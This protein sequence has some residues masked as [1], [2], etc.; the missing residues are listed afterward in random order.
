MTQPEPDG[1]LIGARQRLQNAIAALID[2]RRHTLSTGKNTWLDSVYQQ[3]AEAVYEKHALGGGRATPASPLWIAASDCLYGIDH[4]AKVEHPEK[5]EPTRQRTAQPRLTHATVWRLQQIDDRTW[6]PQDT[7]HILEFA[8]TLERHTLL[9]ENLLNP[10]TRWYLP[11]PCPRCE[12]DHIYV[13]D[14]GIQV[15]RPALA[16]NESYCRCGNTDCDGFWRSKDF[17]LLGRML[18]NPPPAGAVNW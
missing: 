18:G 7:R 6:R 11:N 16:I 13:D 14:N 10:P 1:N 3:L 9:A 5:P 4:A 12:Q 15:R 17:G 8:A 2:P